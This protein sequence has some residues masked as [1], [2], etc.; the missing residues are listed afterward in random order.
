MTHC[1]VLRHRSGSTT[2]CLEQQ[3]RSGST[4][5]CLEQQDRSG[6]TTHCLEQQDRTASSKHCLEQQ[7]Q[8]GSSKH[9]LEQRDCTASTT[10]CHSRQ[11]LPIGLAVSSSVS[12]LRTRIPSAELLTP[13]GRQ[14]GEYHLN[15]VY[16]DLPHITQLWVVVV[17]SLTSQQHAS[18]S[19]GRICSN[20]FICCHTEIEV[21]DQTFHLTQS[22]YTDTGPTSPSTDLITP[23][24]WQGSHW[25]V[26]F[27][28]TGMTRPRKNPE[29]FRSRG[30]RL[31]H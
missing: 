2:H 13:G 19:Q 8:S 3:D 6:S 29:T 10:H 17:G 24:A 12:I 27:E 20:I 26:N 11:K 31:N 22:R 21:A 5:H 15:S 28:V 16:T 14:G 4:T 30:G 7:A 9:C 18:V 25:S 1:L 23:G